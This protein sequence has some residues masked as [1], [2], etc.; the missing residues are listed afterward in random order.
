MNNWRN[1]SSDLRRIFDREPDIFLSDWAQASCFI[2][3]MLI[4]WC[5]KSNYK[6]KIV[7]QP[8]QVYN[9]SP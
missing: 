6:D 7:Y 1:N 3:N 2:T 4:L 8:A 5:M 9:E